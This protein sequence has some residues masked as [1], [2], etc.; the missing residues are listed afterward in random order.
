MRI[1]HITEK[2]GVTY[3]HAEYLVARMLDSR[4]CIP[5]GWYFSKRSEVHGDAYEVQSVRGVG[6]VVTVP[7]GTIIP[8]S[9]KPTWNPEHYIPIAVKF[10]DGEPLTDVPKHLLRSK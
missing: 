3:I 8:L 4:P 7:E 2:D 1:D 10:G 5:T 6:I 9:G